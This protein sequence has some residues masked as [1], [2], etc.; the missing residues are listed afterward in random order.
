MVVFD[1]IQGIMAG[2]PADLVILTEIGAMII[3][4]T[5]F[6]YFVKIIKQPLIPAYILTGIILGPLVLVAQHVLEI[7]E[8]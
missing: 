2:V 1:L 4:A 7:Q 3:I 5:V 6:A 8:I